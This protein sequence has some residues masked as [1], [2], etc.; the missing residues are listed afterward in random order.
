MF[1]KS[2]I[3]A[4]PA[5]G[6]FI[7]QLI[8]CFI[9]CNSCYVYLEVIFSK[10][11]QTPSRMYWLLWNVF[12]TDDKEYLYIF[13]RL[14]HDRIQLITVS[15]LPWATRQVSRGTQELYS[16]HFQTSE[17]PSYLVVVFLIL[18]FLALFWTVMCLFTSVLSVLL[19]VVPSLYLKP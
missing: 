16:H 8:C 19:F 9:T 7:S 2:N 14:G 6:A 11:T 1:Y 12:V 18:I 17:S 15:F 3:L 10:R 4:A 5:N 13:L